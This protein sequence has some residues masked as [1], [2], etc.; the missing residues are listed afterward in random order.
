MSSSSPTAANAIVA[1]AAPETS[2]DEK[3]TKTFATIIPTGIKNN[4]PNVGV[5]FFEEC[6]T[7]ALLLKI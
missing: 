3:P 4:P 6:L 7:E 2:V 5:L 1:T